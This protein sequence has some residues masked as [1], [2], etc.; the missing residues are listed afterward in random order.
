MISQILNTPVL[1]LIIYAAM[2]RSFGRKYCEVYPCLPEQFPVHGVGTM[3]LMSMTTPKISRCHDGRREFSLAG[4][5]EGLLSP[6]RIQAGW[7]L[8]Q[9]WRE[10]LHS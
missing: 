1:L 4:G 5:P 9:K 3:V 8:T 7:I 6:A 2:V 10:I